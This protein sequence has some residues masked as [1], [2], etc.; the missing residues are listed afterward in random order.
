MNGQDKGAGV[1][2]RECWVARRPYQVWLSWAAGLRL[3]CQ[4]GFDSSED[5]MYTPTGWVLVDEVATGRRGRCW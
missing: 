2:T 1:A 3:F 4:T 5:A